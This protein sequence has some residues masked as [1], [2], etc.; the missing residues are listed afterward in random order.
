MENERS[1]ENDTS[2]ASVD[3][4]HEIHLDVHPLCLHSC[5]AEAIIRVV[6]VDDRRVKEYMYLDQSFL[7]RSWTAPVCAARVLSSNCGVLGSV[8][9]PPLHGEGRIR[10]PTGIEKR[11]S[12]RAFVRRTGGRAHLTWHVT[13][14]IDTVGS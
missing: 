13:H 9:L 11:Q 12:N 2:Y 14:A 8:P 10:R 3:W 4:S 1:C 7:V 6:G 5:T